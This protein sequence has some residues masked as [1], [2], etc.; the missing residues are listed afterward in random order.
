MECGDLKCE[1]RHRVCL[2]HSHGCRPRSQRLTMSSLVPTTCSLCYH[3]PPPPLQLAPCAGT[4]PT[5]QPVTMVLYLIGLGLGDENDITLRGL[6]AVQSCSHVFL[7][8]YTSIL[9]AVSKERLRSAYSCA[10]IVTADREMVESGAEH[11]LQPAKD[12]NVAFL[13]VGDPFASAAPHLPLRSHQS[14]AGPRAYAYP[15]QRLTCARRSVVC[16]GL[17]LTTTCSCERRVR[18][19]RWRWC[20]TPPSTMRCRPRV[21][22]CITSGR[23]CPSPSSATPGGPTV[24]TTDCRSTS[25]PA[26]TA[27]ASSTSK[28]GNRAWTTWPSQH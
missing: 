1:T 3:L 13:V 22:S 16:A 21:C 23:R 12:G 28:S 5:P 8:E 4:P 11:I 9:G 7:E 18:A 20:T 26:S 2:F 14:S 10:K 19:S 25:A 15:L 17:R 6:K 27:S 24:S